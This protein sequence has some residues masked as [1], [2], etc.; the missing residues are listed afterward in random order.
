MR[1]TWFLSILVTMTIVA[2]GCEERQLERADVIVGDVND[3]VAGVGALL[4]SPAG[5]MLP[6]DIKLYAA[7]AV[8][9]A[10]IAVNS[11]QGIKGNLMKKTTKAIVKGI[12]L[13]D[14][15]KA[16]PMSKVKKSIQDEMILAGVFDRGNQI[17]DKLK[18][19]R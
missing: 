13:A 2:A 3:I 8:A 17:V 5:A 11:W 16:N 9:L 1:I 19:A 14:K 12:E 6:P 18:L 4:E 10:S 7:A 15:Q